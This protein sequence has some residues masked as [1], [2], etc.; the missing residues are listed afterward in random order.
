MGV[1]KFSKFPKLGFSQLWG[2]IILFVNL[3]LKWQLKKSFSHGWELSKVMWHAT[4][5]QGNRGNSRLLMVGNQIGNLTPG[6][7]F[8]HN[9]CVKYSNGSCELILNIYVPKAFHWYKEIFNPIGFDPCNCSLKIWESIRTSI[10]KV[11]A[12]LG[13]WR[14]IPSH[15]PTFPGAWNAT[16]ELHSWPTP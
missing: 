10:P 5:T 8:G 4:C 13:A 15:S 11:E 1:A 6:P 9:L 12:H 14:F 7:S 2:P 16:F 3:W